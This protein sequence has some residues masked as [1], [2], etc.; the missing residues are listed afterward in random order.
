MFDQYTIPQLVLMIQELVAE[1][2]A[3][4]FMTPWDRIEVRQDEDDV[5]G[6]LDWALRYLLNGN[7]QLSPGVWLCG[8]YLVQWDA[9]PGNIQIVGR[10]PQLPNV[11]FPLLRE[12][13]DIW[14]SPN[15]GGWYGPF[16]R[17]NKA[18]KRQSNRKLRRQVNTMLASMV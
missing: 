15:D 1:R 16:R 11:E 10:L 4:E 17:V 2:K 3:F 9:A 7:K 6:L 13:S 12:V 5:A 8:D 14:S 18:W